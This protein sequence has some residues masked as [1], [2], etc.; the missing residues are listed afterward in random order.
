MHWSCKEACNSTIFS[1]ALCQGQSLFLLDVYVSFLLMIRSIP[2][3]AVLLRI[4][5]GS[6]SISGGVI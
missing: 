4:F 1:T 5:I 2:G 3:I 6:N